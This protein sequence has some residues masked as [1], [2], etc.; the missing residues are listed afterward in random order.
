MTS[1]QILAVL[2]VLKGTSAF[3]ENVL[4]KRME[5][6]YTT[7]VSLK[8]KN[9]DYSPLLTRETSS[10]YTKQ[11]RNRSE[12]CLA[13]L[14]SQSPRSSFILLFTANIGVS[15]YRF[16]TDFEIKPALCLLQS[17]MWDL[18]LFLP[19]LKLC[20]SNIFPLLRVLLSRFG[21]AYLSRSGCKS[22][23]H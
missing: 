13:L 18:L 12:K 19:Q 23:V 17:T 21:R 14:F 2:V 1:L 5:K 8:K 11:C 6:H 9:L 15:I 7:Y 16:V 22:T 10:G 3:L 20:A 4:L